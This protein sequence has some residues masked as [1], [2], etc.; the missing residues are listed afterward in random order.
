MVFDLYYNICVWKGINF[1]YNMSA[2]M[3]EQ[4]TLITIYVNII[5]IVRM[6]KKVK[7]NFKQFFTQTHENQKKPCTGKTKLRRRSRAEH[8]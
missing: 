5:I 4:S 1:V 2:R 7:L 3:I 8:L 6:Y